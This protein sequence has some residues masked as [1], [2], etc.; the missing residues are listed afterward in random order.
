M[1]SVTQRISQIIQPSGG[2][3]KPSEF[4]K[5]QLN[6]GKELGEENVHAGVIGMTVDYLTRYI[7]DREAHPE[8]RYE[9][10]LFESFYISI[11]GYKIKMKLVDPKEIKMDEKNG[12]EIMQLL[13]R[14]KGLDDESIIAAVK[15]TTYDVWL[16]NTSF[17]FT[18]KGAVDTNPDKT[19]INNIRIFVERSLEFWKKYGPITVDGF[20]F[21]K[22][23]YTATVDSGDG[24][25]LT[26]DTLWDFK[27]SK[28]AP[29]N[30]HTLQLLM[31]WI[32][33]KHSKKKE[34]KDITKIGI[35]NPRLN[36]VYLYD[37]NK[38][39]VDIIKD[40][41]DNVICY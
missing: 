12:V 20:T 15:A 21:E 29:T 28:S 2:Y 16:R 33:G 36:T 41:E 31:Y 5:I 7:K 1:A 24:D 9:Y 10:S 4:E 39:S 6:D 19:T 23:G 26:K 32:M 17:A 38:L 22:D 30:K 34:F 11:E 8:K 27:V 40:I 14:I 37:L 25:Y 35:F 18:S 13:S 3:L